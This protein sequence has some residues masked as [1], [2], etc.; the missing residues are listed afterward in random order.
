M[1]KNKYWNDMTS[2]SVDYGVTFRSLCKLTPGAP[3][4]HILPQS[5]MMG[6][7]DCLLR[8]GSS[9]LGWDSTS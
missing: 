4:R 7:G 8:M 1:A 6:G 5:P 3:S 2:P 9:Y